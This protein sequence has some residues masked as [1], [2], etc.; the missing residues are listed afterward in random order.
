MKSEP[1]EELSALRAE[2]AAL[3]AEQTAWHAI[4]TTKKEESILMQ[5]MVS[6][7]QAQAKKLEEEVAQMESN[8]D[9]QPLSEDSSHRTYAR[10]RKSGK[11]KR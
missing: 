3:L 8:N 9:K 4:L 2:K 11:H 7:L 5:R 1:E 10:Q 6:E